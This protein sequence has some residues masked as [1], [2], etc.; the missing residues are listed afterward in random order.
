MASRTP[1]EANSERCSQLHADGEFAKSE[2]D[3]SIAP[4][5]ESNSSKEPSRREKIFRAIA[6][7]PFVTVCGLAFGFTAGVLL[8][9]LISPEAPGTRDYVFYWATGQQLAHHANPYD[10]VA[11]TT[12]ERSAGASYCAESRLDAKSAV[13]ASACLSAW[14]HRFASGMGNLVIAFNRMHGGFGLYAVDYPRPTGESTKPAWLLLWACADLPHFWADHD[15]C[16][17][18]NRAF[19]APASLASISGGMRTL[20]LRAE[21]ASLSAIR[22]GAFGVG[23]RF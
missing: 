15:V 1:D 9:V 4:E 10:P 12:L 19:F 8:V 2:S 23:S 20:A 21:T 3:L 16:T 11:A 22:G 14:I 6:T 17:A 13:G 7:L 5:L 18:G